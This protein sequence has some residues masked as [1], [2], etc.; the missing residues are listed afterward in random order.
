MKKYEIKIDKDTEIF[1][2]SLDKLSKDE[3]KESTVA[4]TNVFSA[5]EA[6]I[7]GIKMILLKKNMNPAVC[8]NLIG[9]AFITG[10]DS[11]DEIF[12]NENDEEKLHA[13]SRV[14][15]KRLAKYITEYS[16]TI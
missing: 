4:I 10:I 6:I 11:S 7:E 13:K 16:K 15:A 8:M 9:E 1:K 14:I 12:P 3:I 5:Q 2:E